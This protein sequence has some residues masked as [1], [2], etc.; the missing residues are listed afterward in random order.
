MATSNAIAV[1]NDAAALME[2]VV[3]GG[4]LSKLSAAER[5]AYFKQ[6]CES[7]GLNPLTRPFQYISLSGKLT[8]YATKDCTEQLR[9][10]HG[11]SLRIVGRDV[12][13]DVY[14][15][16][17]EATDKTG[18]V[19]C[20]TGAVAVA[21]LKGEAKANAF[22]KAETKAKRRVTL[23]ICGL[24]MLDES[25]VDSIPGAKPWSDEPTPATKGG[26][27]PGYA[28]MGAAPAEVVT[29]NIMA[30]LPSALE[31]NEEE[32][33][34]LQEWI[35]STAADVAG[36]CHFFDVND[37]TELTPPQYHRALAMLQKKAAKGAA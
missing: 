37:I 35:D 21:N 19:D 16:T 33:A 27:I 30:D 8:L 4:D 13:D 2:K 1:A 12:M 3:V 32:I 36:L 9:K 25:E 31:I 24:G 34:T 15:V 7:L 17:A 5:M 18:R 29:G 6:T 28:P 11:V 10:T 20:A 26:E 14:V 22:M 23:S